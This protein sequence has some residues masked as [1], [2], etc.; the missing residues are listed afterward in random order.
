MNYSD[1][2]SIIALVISIVSGI[3]S[4]YTYFA[5]ARQQKKCDTVEA[6]SKLQN[7]VLDK[8]ASFTKRNKRCCREQI[9]TGI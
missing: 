3:F 4:V 9:S 7:E 6:F 2:L 1:I 5:S 8:L